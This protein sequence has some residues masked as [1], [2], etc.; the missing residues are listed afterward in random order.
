MFI[1]LMMF[2]RHVIN[3]LSD[4]VTDKNTTHEYLAGSGH[5]DID[6]TRGDVV[7]IPGEPNDEFDADF[8]L[9]KLGSEQHQSD[10]EYDTIERPGNE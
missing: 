1:I 3:F 10:K 8:L 5:A 9:Q 7:D 2:Y 4:I 6:E